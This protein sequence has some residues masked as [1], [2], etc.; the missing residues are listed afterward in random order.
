[1]DSAILGNKSR[2]SWIWSTFS[3]HELSHINTTEWSEIDRGQVDTLDWVHL[4]FG[5]CCERSIL[6]TKIP[7]CA[8]NYVNDSDFPDFI[9]GS[10][11]LNLVS[12]LTLYRYQTSLL[13]LHA[14]IVHPKKWL[15]SRF[16]TL[17]SKDS[18]IQVLNSIDHSYVSVP[19][20]SDH[21]Y[22]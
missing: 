7:T 6:S 3:D 20:A 12:L 5:I 14:I 19:G 22:H 16:S 10:G 17:I 21:S 13:S 1:M 2:K 15:F 9:W 11:A 18:W 8:E 4:N